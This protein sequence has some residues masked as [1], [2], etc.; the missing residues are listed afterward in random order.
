MV[1]RGY[2]RLQL[3][4]EDVSADGA[5]A[6][7]PQCDSW[8]TDQSN[9]GLRIASIFII[10]VSSL[11]GVLLPMLLA[12]ASKM[13]VPKVSFFIAKYFGSGVILATAFIHLLSPA[14]EAL[15][16]PCL[17]DLL[18]EYDWAQGIA[19]MTVVV[20][21]FIELMAARF[22]FGFAHAHSTPANDPSLSLLGAQGPLQDAEA[23]AE[24]ETKVPDQSGPKAVVNKPGAINVPGLPN[25]VSYPPGGENHLGHRHQHIEGDS[26]NAY[27][28]QL[29]VSHPSPPHIAA[30]LENRQGGP[31]PDPLTPLPPLPKL[32]SRMTR[33]DPINLKALL[34]LEFGVVFHSFFIGLAL[35]GT[36]ELIVL[37]IVIT[38]HQFFEG[39]GL[40]S[41][42][43]TATWPSDW[44]AWTPWAMALGYGITTP[45]GIAV[46]LA[47]NQS[48]ADN[49][50]RAQLAN[51]IFDA[52]SAGILLYTALVELLAHEFMFNPEMRNA[53]LSMQMFAFGCVAVGTAIM[54]VLGKWA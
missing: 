11:L 19:L 12:R 53:S 48:L 22:D 26:H 23:E 2:G 5:D 15:N 25:D 44:K 36:D 40:G 28:T 9:R 37:V 41:R 6:Q 4:Q 16:D 39:L 42:L 50:A 52:V 32:G 31:I 24:A 49:A 18:P 43:A 13:H 29:T 27:G 7:T 34:I 46:G 33:A 47:V 54:A 20:M 8:A 10:L 30:T 1:S 3:R 45:L 35:A 21:F 17:A 14:N 51:G 38:F